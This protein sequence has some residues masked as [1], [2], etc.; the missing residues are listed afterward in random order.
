MSERIPLRFRRLP[1]GAFLEGFQGGWNGAVL[2]FDPARPEGSVAAGDLLEIECGPVLYLG[3]VKQW[4]GLT[5]VVVVEHSIN[6]S[7]LPEFE[8][9]WV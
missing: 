4:R 9:T 5:A 1:D 8:K 2:E 7:E 3:Q 6:L